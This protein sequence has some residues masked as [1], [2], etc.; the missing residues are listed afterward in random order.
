MEQLVEQA[1][2][3]YNAKPDTKPIA[4]FDYEAGRPVEVTFA[5]TTPEDHEANFQAVNELV[6]QELEAFRTADGNLPAHATSIIT[7]SI[8]NTDTVPKALFSNDPK[9]NKVVIGSTGT[10]GMAVV[11]PGES[12]T[13]VLFDSSSANGGIHHVAPGARGVISDRVLIQHLHDFFKDTDFVHAF[14]PEQPL[15]NSVLVA[16]HSAFLPLLIAFVRQLRAVL[17]DPTKIGESI[18]AMNE[19]VGSQVFGPAP[20]VRCGGLD[21]PVA[22]FTVDALLASWLTTNESTL[23][24]ATKRSFH[25]VSELHSPPLDLALA[26]LGLPPIAHI[27]KEYVLHKFAQYIKEHAD[28]QIKQIMEEQ[29]GHA[30]PQEIEALESAFGFRVKNLDGSTD[31]KGTARVYPDMFATGMSA[32]PTAPVH[33]ATFHARVVPLHAAVKA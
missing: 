24:L 28:E 21:L 27:Y 3:G 25:Y 17:A 30:H 13:V 23:A 29:K 4:G 15:E 1:V 9:L 16:I 22:A 31:T 8:V 5:S 26:A 6:K 33:F 32:R 2:E 18:P 20:T 14:R 12:K 19:R 11:A 10:R 7:A